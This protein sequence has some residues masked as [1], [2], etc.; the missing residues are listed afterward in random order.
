MDWPNREAGA[1]MA[2]TVQWAMLGLGA[3]AMPKRT[4]KP[5]TPAPTELL[6][7]R[8]AARATAARSRLPPGPTHSAGRAVV[9]L[10]P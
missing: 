5:A 2:T 4:Q 10:H 3:V 6:G 7:P 9:V 1:V 8:P